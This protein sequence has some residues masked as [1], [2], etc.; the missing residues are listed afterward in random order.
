[1]LASVPALGPSS[2]RMSMLKVE[3]W[4][5]QQEDVELGLRTD[6]SPTSP[7]RRK[8]GVPFPDFQ[9][10]TGDPLSRDRRRLSGLPR[11]PVS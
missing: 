10:R 3:D 7:S 2:K 1:M 9:D 5:K 4:K 6:K 8:S 11:D